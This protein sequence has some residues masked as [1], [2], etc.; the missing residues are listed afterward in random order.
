ML[1]S[2]D[3]FLAELGPKLRQMRVERGWTYRQMIVDHGF[4]LAHWQSFEKGKGISVPSLFR[5]CEVFN[6]P[7]EEL[8]AGMGVADQVLSSRQEAASSRDGAQGSTTSPA[9]RKRTKSFSSVAG[10]LPGPSPSA[11]ADK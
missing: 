10:V 4:H 8:I 5:I 1:Y 9:R 11:R 3:K 2:Y 6:I 7:L